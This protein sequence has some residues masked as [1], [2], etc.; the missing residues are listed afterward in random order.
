VGPPSS[1][2]T[3]GSGPVETGVTIASTGDEAS[4][5]ASGMLVRDLVALGFDAAKSPTIES[6]PVPMVIVTIEVRPEGPQ[7]EAKLRAQKQ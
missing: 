1:V 3:I 4:R 2:S 5:N 6:R 7:G